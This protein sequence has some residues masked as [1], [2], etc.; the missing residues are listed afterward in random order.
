MT[1]IQKT[2]HIIHMSSIDIKSINWDLNNREIAESLG[3]TPTLIGYYR[4][5]THLRKF[6]REKYRIDWTKVDWTKPDHEI[7]KENNVSAPPVGTARRRFAPEHLRHASPSPQGL[8]SYQ[9]RMNAERA[10]K[11][12]AAMRNAAV[13]YTADLIQQDAARPKQTASALTVANVQGVSIVTPQSVTTKPASQQQAQPSWVKRK[14]IALRDWLFNVCV[15]V[16]K[17]ANK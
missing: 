15:S 13:I 16:E 9:R 11:E 8:K 3:V 6:K 10:A 7:A 12:A 5:Q 14:L 1:P 2:E 4:K 17:E